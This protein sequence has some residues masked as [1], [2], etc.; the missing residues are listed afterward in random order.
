MRSLDNI[1]VLE[2]AG[3]APGPFAGLLL[4]DNGAEVLR[5][6]RVQPGPAPSPD[7]LI[8]GKS[9]IRIDLKSTDGRALFL[10]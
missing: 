10:Q 8:R 5:V 9:S 2:L 4:A 3:L 7:V 1:R 6:D